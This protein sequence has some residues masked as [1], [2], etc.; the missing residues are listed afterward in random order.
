MPKIIENAKNHQK[1]PKINLLECPIPPPPLSV[2]KIRVTSPLTVFLKHGQL[3]FSK[4]SDSISNYLTLIFPENQ[5][6]G[7]RHELE[8]HMLAQNI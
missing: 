1:S 7:S 8:H 2:T 6:S 3:D 5:V 4:A